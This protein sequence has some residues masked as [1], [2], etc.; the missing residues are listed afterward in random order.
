MKL[1][2]IADAYKGLEELFDVDEL[3]YETLNDT[4]EA[5]DGA[6]EVKADNIATFIKSKQANAKAIKDEIGN[7]KA[8]MDRENDSVDYL[9]KYLSDLMLETGNKKIETPRNVISFRKSTSVY[10]ENEDAFTVLH[11]GF[12]KTK[13]EISINK[14]AVADQLKEGKIIKGAELKS[15]QNIQIK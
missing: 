4:L 15:K 9:K 6:F 8:R 1:Y 2:E 13:T 3:D 12:L 14:K 11:P 7:L 10:I 5:I